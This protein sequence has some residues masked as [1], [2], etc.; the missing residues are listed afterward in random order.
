MN[1]VSRFAGA[2]AMMLLVAA[3]ATA[4]PPVT[5]MEGLGNHH[6]PI[7]TEASEA[8]KFF[9]QGL[10]LTFGF[11]HAEAIRAFEKAHELDPAS[12][13]PLWGKALALGPNYNIDID[14]VQREARLRDDRRGPHARGECAGTRAGLCRS[15]GGTLF[16]RCEPRSQ[17]ARRRLCQGH[18]RTV[19]ALSGRSRRRDAPCREPDE[20]QAVEAVESRSSSRRRRRSRS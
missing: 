10:I 20:P 5:L 2:M 11:N 6:H 8:Q 1:Q 15:A 3:P 4:D 16:G 19:G 14:P 9:D 12:P 7:A 17:A 13:M 18:G